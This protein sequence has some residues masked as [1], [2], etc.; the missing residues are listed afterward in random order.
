MV[1]EMSILKRESAKLSIEMPQ[2]C[3][4]LPYL[5]ETSHL[6]VRLLSPVP[7]RPHGRQSECQAP[8]NAKM[9]KALPVLIPALS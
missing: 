7:E 8:E 4:L 1:S 2:T 5:N 9:L 6:P 3:S